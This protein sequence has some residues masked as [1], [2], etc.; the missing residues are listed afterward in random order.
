L[1]PTGK[2]PVQALSGVLSKRSKRHFGIVVI[3]KDH[4]FAYG[5][6]HE[7][8]TSPRPLKLSYENKIIEDLRELIRS[9][10]E[11]LKVEG[12]NRIVMRMRSEIEG[13]TEAWRLE[14]E[15]GELESGNRLMRVQME[16]VMIVRENK[17]LR[18][19]YEEL[20]K[21]KGREMIFFFVL[22]FMVMYIIIYK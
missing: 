19:D 5:A 16:N 18:R 15:R 1:Y 22:F 11:T 7:A 8:S 9:S 12:E 14:M 13:V 21:R 4:E 20:L 17:L 6:H 10:L 2:G 3:P